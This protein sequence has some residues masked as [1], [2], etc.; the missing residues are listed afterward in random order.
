MGRFQLGLLCVAGLGFAADCMEVGGWVPH[1]LCWC[2][3]VSMGLRGPRDSIRRKTRK[4]E[5]V[6]WRWV[7]GLGGACI[8]LGKGLGRWVGH[9]ILMGGRLCVR[10]RT[11]DPVFSLPTIHTYPNPTNHR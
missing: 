7:G 8:G 9:L 3:I 4:K 2:F 10:V 11:D 5:S 6:P 1:M